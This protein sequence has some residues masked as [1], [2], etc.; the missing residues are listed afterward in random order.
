MGKRVIPEIKGYTKVDVESFMKAKIKSDPQWAKRACIVLLDQQT[1]TER[2][3]H[4][5]EGHNNVGFGRMDSPLLTK[6]GAKINQHRATPE[7]IARLQRRLSRYARQLI[8][9]AYDKDKG[10]NLKKH[11]DFYYR[12]ETR[13]MPY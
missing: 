4:L 9:L 11:L 5:S 8:C 13:H 6:I 1:P 7:D 12:N 10:K 3:N 2:R